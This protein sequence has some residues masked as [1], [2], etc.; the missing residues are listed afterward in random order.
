MNEIKQE[1]RNHNNGKYKQEVK[2]NKIVKK[3]KIFRKIFYL[4]LLVILIII[5]LTAYFKVKDVIR[6]YTKELD[7][8]LTTENSTNTSNPSDNIITTNNEETINSGILNEYLQKQKTFQ[9][10]ITKQIDLLNKKVNESNLATTTSNTQ[11]NNTNSVS[12]NSPKVN[13]SNIVELK[14][15]LN[16]LN[17]AK[18]NAY[19]LSKIY[20]LIL[21]LNGNKPFYQELNSLQNTRLFTKYQSNIKGLSIDSSIGI[22]SNFDLLNSF[23]QI[24]P[25]IKVEM[26]KLDNSFI[27]KIKYYLSFFIVVE[28]QSSFTS[29]IIS[30]DNTFYQIRLLLT[31][32]QAKEALSLVKNQNFCNLQVVSSWC[33]SLTSRTEANELVQS[34][35]QYLLNIQTMEN[36]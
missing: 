31:N 27:G 23:N 28:K 7:I 12:N 8:S 26:Y 18:Q 36:K 14:N 4:I 35:Q 32:N 34:L 13:S 24:S 25:L 17:A 3:K 29:N 2:N 21:V 15:T 10:E 19:E 16:E 22:P 5:L 9:E 20:Q 30:L 11:K 33:K 6:K 1:V